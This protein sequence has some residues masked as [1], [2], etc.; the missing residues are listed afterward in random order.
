MKAE[1]DIEKQ[2]AASQNAWDSQPSAELWDRLEQRLEEAQPT[3]GPR[4]P[5]NWPFR[6]VSLLLVI[7]IGT[8][9][10]LA[11]PNEKQEIPMEKTIS[12]PLIA[13]TVAE[14]Q[15]VQP[16]TVMKANSHL[17]FGE[18]VGIGESVLGKSKS[19]TLG[20]KTGG[21]FADFRS[22]RL[23]LQGATK[24]H[25]GNGNGAVKNENPGAQASYNGSSVQINGGF[26]MNNPGTANMYAGKPELEVTANLLPAGNMLVTN[27]FGNPID[28]VNSLQQYSNLIQN[29]DNNR[30]LQINA[31]RNDMNFNF[32]GPST[33]GNQE[34]LQHLK[35]LLG[36]WKTQGAS[37][38]AIEEWRQL[39]DFTLVGRGYF[40]VNGD[41]I[42]T[43]EMRIEQRGPNVYYIIAKDENAKAM[44]FRLRSRMSNELIFQDE[45]PKTDQELIL[46]NNPATNEIE[47]I[48]TTPAE[49]TGNLQKLSGQSLPDNRKVMQ[50]K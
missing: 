36:S 37:G 13:E 22:Q 25:F 14:A 34:N 16:D 50:R 29:N 15:A 4:K 6:I 28:T 7:G 47:K 44:K 17:T 43:Q 26:P 38:G 40:V 20:G 31:A 11:W 10:W 46:R 42:V 30:Y 18:N 2:L 8:G 9:I 19:T 33:A 27:S 1:E 35:W 3:I 21:L 12:A 45:G 39:D 48:I 32:A 41:T 49:R 23:G 24:M 5:K